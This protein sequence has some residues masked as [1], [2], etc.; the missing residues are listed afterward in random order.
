MEISAAGRFQAAQVLVQTSLASR[1][2]PSH[3]LCGVQMRG[4]LV[5]LEAARA[6]STAKIFFPGSARHVLLPL[7]VRRRSP[8]FIARPVANSQRFSMTQAGDPGLVG[9]RARSR[10]ES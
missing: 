5:H 3:E 7:I 2:P 1:S 9:L 8:R 10:D 6:G 4:T